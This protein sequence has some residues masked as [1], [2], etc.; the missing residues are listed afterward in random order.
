MTLRRFCL[1]EQDG[2]PSMHSAVERHFPAWRMRHL[3]DWREPKTI[4]PRIKKTA[5]RLIDYWIKRD[6]SLHDVTKQMHH[7]NNNGVDSMHTIPFGSKIPNPAEIHNKSLVG[8]D[9]ML[10][11]WHKRVFVFYLQK[12]HLNMSYIFWGVRCRKANQ[13]RIYVP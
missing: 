5:E 9:W 4:L 8:S 12:P 3:T 11:F 6:S 13:V 2:Y 1:G 10:L 7:W